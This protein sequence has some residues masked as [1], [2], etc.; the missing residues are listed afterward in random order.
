MLTISTSDFQLHTS[1]WL[2]YATEENEALLITNKGEAKFE[3]KPVNVTKKVLF[4]AMKGTCKTLGDIVNPLEDLGFT[5][6]EEN[7]FG[8]S[9]NA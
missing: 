5:N 6:D 9:R 4:G 7:I 8:N 3:L 1:K 2:K